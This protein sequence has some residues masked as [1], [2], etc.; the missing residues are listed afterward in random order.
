MPQ[1]LGHILVH[2]I[3]ST[4][5]RRPFLNPANRPRMHAYLA[6]LC[7]DLKCEAY[8]VGGVSDHVHLA[9]RLHRTISVAALV[10][11]IKKKSS[12]WIKE[13]GEEYRDFYW[14]SGYGAFSVSPPHLEDLIRYIDN[15]EEHHRKESFQDEYRKFLRRYGIDFDE[16][17]VWD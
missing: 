17:Y 13:E 8:R 16:R 3:F 7:R 10:E 2:L 6:T 9:I 15:Q 12:G 11:D 1:S 5:E 14:Q 4:K